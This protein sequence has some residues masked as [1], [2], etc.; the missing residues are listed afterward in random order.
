MIRIK[1]DLRMKRRVFI[2]SLAIVLIL[3]IVAS[4]IAEEVYKIGAILP[5]TGGTAMVG[6]HAQKGMILATEDINTA[7]GIYGKKLEIVIGDSKNEPKEGVAIFHRFA[8][9][10]RLPVVVSAMS[11]VSMAVVPLADQYKIVLATTIVSAPGITEKSPW[12]F[13]VFMST[14]SEAGAMKIFILKNMG[15]KKIAVLYINDE[16]GRTAFE[17]F[18]KMYEAEGGKVIWSDSFEKA[19]IDFRSQIF[20]L[21]AAKPKGVYIIGYDKALGIILRQI[22]EAKIKTRL[23]S[24]SGLPTPTVLE[25]AGKATEGVYFTST[26]FNVENP[27]TKATEEFVK[28]YKARFGKAPNHYAAYTYDVTSIIAE[29][30]RIG[31]YSAEGIKSGLSKIKGFTG[32]IG[33]I[34]IPLSRDADFPVVVKIIRQGKPIDIEENKTK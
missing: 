19:G 29:A 6:E 5:L 18:K 24:F 4:S 2:I 34:T 9:I 20:K 22:A 33:A 32:V 15:L 21:K 12:V 28:K 31:G 17:V 8:S 11:S 14:D 30:I 23:F 7:G 16:F 10:N 1:E 13:R 26:Q 3:G 27:T 25:H